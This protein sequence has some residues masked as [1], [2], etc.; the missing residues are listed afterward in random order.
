MSDGVKIDVYG[1]WFA[2]RKA[3]LVN[4]KPDYETPKLIGGINKV[5]VAYT[6]NRT[7]AFENGGSIY[8][9]PKISDA[10]VTIDTHTVSLEDRMM[11]YYGL[12]PAGAA[13]NGY[14]EGGDSDVATVG[15]IGYA[16]KI[17]GNKWLCTWWYNGCAEP[18]DETGET[19]DDSG[20][21]ITPDSIVFNCIMDPDYRKR[22]RTKIVEGVDN[23]KAFFAKVMPEAA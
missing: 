9:K 5:G 15:A 1:F 3:E 2:Q 7:K 23:M 10:N 4:E 22:R 17:D 8:N 11:L 6:K 12:T 13:E 18:A 20:E 14:E 16:I 21:K 19:S